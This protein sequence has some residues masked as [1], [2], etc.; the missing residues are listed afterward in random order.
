[1]LKE[2]TDPKED[3]VQTAQPEALVGMLVGLDKVTGLKR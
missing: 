3:G 2:Q 1:M